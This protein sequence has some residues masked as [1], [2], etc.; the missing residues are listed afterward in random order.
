MLD[1]FVNLVSIALFEKFPNT[2]PI[3]N[4]ML[5]ISNSLMIKKTANGITDNFISQSYLRV[6]AI[7]FMN[8][9]EG[10]MSR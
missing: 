6:Y 4:T 3:I 9:Q 5:V 7:H 8:R 2:Y 10:D 1:I